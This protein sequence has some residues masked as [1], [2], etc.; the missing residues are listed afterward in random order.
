[1]IRQYTNQDIDAVVHVWRQASAKAHPFLSPKFMDSEE[2]NVRHVYPKYAKIWVKEL[3]GTIIGFIAMIESE[4]GAIFLHPDFHGQGIGKEMMDFAANRHET[5]TLDIFQDNQ[6]GRRFYD[7]YGF[8]Q[9]DQYL[10]EPSGQQTIKM[11]Y[12]RPT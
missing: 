10:H 8:I 9:T 3:D 4:V 6:I 11:L 5:L 2:E 12:Q 7:R 1:M